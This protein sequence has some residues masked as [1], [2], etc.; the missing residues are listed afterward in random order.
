MTSPADVVEREIFIAAPPPVVFRF[1]VEPALMAQWIGLDHQLDPRPGGIFRMEVS[2]GNIARG[3]YTEVTPFRR[4]AF[5]WGW[6][7]QDPTLAMLSPGASLVEFDLEPKDEG[8]LLRL[9]HSRLP[10]DAAAIHRERW[11]LYLARLETV[12]RRRDREAV[13]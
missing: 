5:T 12:A 9:R 10:S 7:S 11:S 6:D 13:T 1:L 3:R 8:T 4:V 2:K